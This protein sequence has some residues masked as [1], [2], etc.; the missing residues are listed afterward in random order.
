MG[1]GDTAAADIA[2]RFDALVRFAGLELGTQLGTDIMPA[3]SWREL[4][5]LVGRTQALVSQMG[6]RA[7]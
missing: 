6:R 1:V 3:P 5:D 4:A 2:G 7:R